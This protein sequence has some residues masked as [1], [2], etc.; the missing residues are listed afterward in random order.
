MFNPERGSS[1]GSQEL[2]IEETGKEDTKREAGELAKKFSEKSFSETYLSEYSTR[3]TEI[4]G[5]DIERQ[6]V[7]RFERGQI[8]KGYKILRQEIKETE[9]RGEDT[10]KN[11]ALLKEIRGRAKVLEKDLDELG[12]QSFENT[13]NIEVQTQWGSFTMPVCE[14]DLR[15]DIKPEDDKR[16]PYFLLGGIGTQHH[17]SAALSMALALEGH[18]V[19]IPTNPEQ[20]S[21]QKPDNYAEDLKKQGDFRIHAELV[22]QIIEKMG[23][24]EVNIVGYSTGATVALELA[25]DNSFDKINDLTVLE[26]L[27]IEN[28]GF[29]RLAKEFGIEQVLLK[30]LPYSEARIKNYQQG[31]EQGEASLPLFLTVA[32]ILSKKLFT[33][34]KLK[35]IHNKGRFQVCI[36][37]SS[38]VMNGKAIEESFAKAEQLKSEQGQKTSSVE[39]YKIKGGDHNWPAT[40]ALGLFKMMT[41]EK[42]KEQVTQVKLKD[43]ENSAMA[44]IIKDS[45]E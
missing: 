36:G 13:R 30:F 29:P 38:P 23:L 24:K 44:R 37:T 11:K 3:K 17:Q 7:F 41:G 22:K 42:P 39:L 26:P 9:K 10:T 15:K 6:P 20:P 1:E 40:N 45:K 34:E 32:K 4:G 2:P 8:Y 27:G 31:K 25:T 5:T 16:V 18:K 12:R 14:L 19:Y 33:P 21:V 43:L 35:N 28:K